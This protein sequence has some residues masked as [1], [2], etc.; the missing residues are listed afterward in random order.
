MTGVTALTNYAYNTVKRAIDTVSDPEYT[1]CNLI[2]MPGLTENTL[3]TH[4]LTTCEDRADALALFDLESTFIPET[5]GSRI[6]K[7][8]ER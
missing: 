8:F 6:T 3:T 1:E 4:L 7:N 5:E 2:T